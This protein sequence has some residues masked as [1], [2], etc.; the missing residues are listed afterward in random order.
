MEQLRVDAD[1][2]HS[3]PWKEA[4]RFSI[5]WKS[6]N[7]EPEAKAGTWRASS[8]AVIHVG[9]GRSFMP[10]SGPNLQL[11]HLNQALLMAFSF[12]SYS[13]WVRSYRQLEWCG[14]CIPI[15]GTFFQPQPAFIAGK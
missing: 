11:C 8:T 10:W 2:S 14:M 15:S 12:P 4:L 3:P 13:P 6:H 5:C 1:L 7:S 9:N